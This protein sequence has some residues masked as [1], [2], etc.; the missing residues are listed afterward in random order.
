M[1]LQ[2]ELLEAY[3]KMKSSVDKM[4][5]QISKQGVDARKS[6]YPWDV[7]QSSNSFI[8]RPIPIPGMPQASS[9]YLVV[10]PADNT[11]VIHLNPGSTIE[12]HVIEGD[13][14]VKQGGVFTRIPHY[15]S[16]TYDKDNPLL[17]DTLGTS[18]SVVTISPVTNLS[19]N[20]K[21]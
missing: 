17:I 7:S 21:F 15:Q 20:E 12:F 3:D 4:N 16:F 13:I 2:R 6:N 8:Y 14:S 11:H 5:S 10:F 1:A 9:I 19:E 18:I